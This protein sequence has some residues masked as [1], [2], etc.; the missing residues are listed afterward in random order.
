VIFDDDTT[1]LSYLIG[2]GMTIIPLEI[3]FLGNAWLSE[4]MMASAYPLVESQVSQQLT[5]VIKADIGIRSAA[6][7]SQQ[8]LIIST[9]NDNLPP[10]PKEV[11]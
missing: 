5:Q 1:D 8:E 6:Q 11:F 10:H 2:F 7:D 4:D 9:H 3:D